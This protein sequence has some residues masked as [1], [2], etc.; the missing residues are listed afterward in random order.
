MSVNAFYDA[1]GATQN[2]LGDPR[3]DAERRRQQE[4]QNA[5]QQRQMQ[6]R[7]FQFGQEQAEAQRA[8]A[9]RQAQMA[10]AR[11]Q[12]QF[13]GGSMYPNQQ[14]QQAAPV[15][16]MTGG[17]PIEQVQG[18][19][20]VD[21]ATGQEGLSYT[22]TAVQRGPAPTPEE[23]LDFLMREAYNRGD[24][25][26]FN[27]YF[28]LRRQNMTAE[29]KAGRQQIA[30]VAGQILRLPAEQRGQAV[31]Q[32]LQQF[33]VDPSTTKIDDYVNNPDQL[34]QALRFEMVMGSPDKAAEENIRVQ[35][36]FDQFRPLE[37]QDLGNRVGVFDPRTG[38]FTDGP[39]VGL[40]PNTAATTATQ[41]QTARI[42]AGSR[43]KAAD[44]QRQ[45]AVAMA[46]AG[47][48]IELVP[49]DDLPDGE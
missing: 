14:P 10:R 16:P 38:R 7:E 35:G 45:G 5:M 25:I 8:E 28:D 44:I 20:F 46:A 15:A 43:I 13:R 1:Y 4:M 41:L 21:P 2:A 11:A 31:M 37:R 32:A 49:A 12:M 6:M 18:Q 33:G 19:A 47:G 27:Q 30:V 26:G 42:G 24:E 36:T 17:A 23:E 3:G 29:E 9:E 39:R 22:A 48:K 34:E 40:S